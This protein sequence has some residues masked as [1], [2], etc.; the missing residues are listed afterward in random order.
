MKITDKTPFNCSTCVEG[1]MR[2]FR[3]YSPD[4]KAEKPLDLVF[5]DL[6]GP[7]CPQSIEGSKYAIVFCRFMYWCYFYIFFAK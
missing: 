5:T 1:K 7:L 2:Q 3:S 4:Q 6:A